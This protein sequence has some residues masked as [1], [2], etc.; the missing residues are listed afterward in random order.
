MKTVVI[1]GVT[2]FTFALAIPYSAESATKGYNT[3]SSS[4]AVQSSQAEQ[5][6][7]GGQ[8]NTPAAAAA[9][10][11]E[12]YNTPANTP[13]APRLWQAGKYTP[14]PKAAQ[15]PQAEQSSQV[16]QYNTPAASP[17]E[18]Y[19]TP[20]NTPAAPRLWQAGK[21][22]PAPKAAQSPQAEQSFQ[23]GQY[24]VESSQTAQPI[25]AEQSAGQYT[26]AAR[27]SPVG[28][29]SVVAQPSQ[30]EQSYGGQSQQSQAAEAT[31]ASYSA[32]SESTSSPSNTYGSSALEG[33]VNEYNRESGSSADEASA[34]VGPTPY[35]APIYSLAQ[36][37][38]YQRGDRYQRAAE[39]NTNTAA[40]GNGSQTPRVNAVTPATAGG[41]HS[42]GGV[43]GGNSSSHGSC[44]FNTACQKDTECGNGKCLGA[45]VGKCNCNAC[46]N[47]VSCKDDKA[48]GGLKSA[49]NTTT[50]RCDCQ[51]GF[52]AAGFPQFFQAF[53]ELCNVKSCSAENSTQSCFGL[54]CHSGR[55]VCTA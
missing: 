45:F 30:G 52:K 39:N 54:P 12:Q 42:Q 21:Y 36:Q 24:G 25:Q 18:Q 46:I 11:V 13:A 31:P 15:S 38:S 33:Q 43:A 3:G 2:A 34:T 50:S 26:P 40:S 14:A 27:S 48:C 4:K 1:L 6:S 23:S 32:A 8:Y 16:E 35:A 9:S 5:Y 53:Q 7:Q 22:T 10:P 28:E 17:V 49:C 19:N 51:E 20:A 29:Y 47:F 37:D 41:Q 44:T 55:C